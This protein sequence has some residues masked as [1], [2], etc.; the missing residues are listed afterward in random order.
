MEHVISRWQFY[1]HAHVSMSWPAVCLAA[2]SAVLPNTPGGGS[3]VRHEA[4]PA[5]VG[6]VRLPRC[7]D[8]LP[9]LRLHGL[10]FFYVLVA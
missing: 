9:R 8:K 3:G 2:V 10:V 1:T 6:Q 5:Q 7:G 4:Q